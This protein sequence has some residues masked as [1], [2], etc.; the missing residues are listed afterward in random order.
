[1][2]LL[3]GKHCFEVKSDELLSLADSGRRHSDAVVRMTAA[4][5]MNK[6]PSPQHTTWLNELLS[7]THIEVRNVA[8]QMLVLTNDQTPDLRTQIVA[9]C[10]AK[11]AGPAADWQGIEQALVILGQIHATGHSPACVPLLNHGR[12]EVEVTSAWLMHLY[13]DRTV[14]A[15][16]LQQI[17]DREAYVLKIREQPD[18]AL[19]AGLQLAH[20]FQLSGLLR[21]TSQ[22]ELISKNF[23]KTCPGGELKRAAAMWSIGLSHQDSPLPG[24]VGQ[25]EGRV[26][27]RSGPNPEREIVR[28]MSVLA[29]GWMNSRS[30]ESV[31]KDSLSVDPPGSLIPQSSRWVLMRLGYEE[32]PEPSANVFGVGGWKLLPA[33]P[34]PTDLLLQSK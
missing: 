32:L 10:A 18:L 1:M 31:L 13:P 9:E 26:Q 34:L 27:D 24:L 22:L 21:E 4:R 28:R 14:A 3:R 25:L 20:L 23:E 15:A 5:L 19:N 17:A 2:P 33:E 29:L 7:D 16:V 11:I 12:P 6:Y 8:R 30:S